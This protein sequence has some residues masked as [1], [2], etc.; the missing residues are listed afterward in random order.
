MVRTMKWSSVP[1][2][3][4]RVRLATAFVLMSASAALARLADRL[5]SQPAAGG[6]VVEVAAIDIAG[7]RVGAVYE[8]GRLV[9]WLP[10]ITRL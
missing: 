6:S 3:P 9:G 2:G 10:D 5:Q 4:P 8:G 1:A 7:R